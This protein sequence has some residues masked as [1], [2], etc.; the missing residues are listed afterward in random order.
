[1]Y[2]LLLDI[3]SEPGEDID[4]HQKLLKETFEFEETNHS[5]PPSPDGAHQKATG[6][7]IITAGLFIVGEI[8][9]AGT[10]ALPAAMSKASYAGFIIM[11]LVVGMSLYCG[12][13]LGWSWQVVKEQRKTTE[14]IKDPFPAIGEAA[15]GIWGRHAVSICLN[16]Q[17]FLTVVV[18]LLLSSEIISS[19]ISFHIGDLH[20]SA[21]L[22]IWLLILSLVVLPFT[23]LGTPK[24][25]WFIALA[26]A[27]TTACA[28]LLIIIKYTLIAPKDL[29]TVE[30][31]PVT[32]LSMASA[33]GTFVF[34]FTGAS[35]FPTVQSDMK[36]PDQFAKA[37]V[38]GYIATCFLYVPTAA[39]GFAVLGKDIEDSILETLSNYDKVHH[40]NRLIVSIVEILFALHFICGLVLM[41]NPFAQQ[42]EGFFN[43]PH[44]K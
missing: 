18:Y 26:A 13:L 14:P 4:G 29:S 1:M 12:L 40:L 17:I 31:A 44:S 8:A 21:N 19:F 9:G 32:F 16:V 23:W 34:A 27:A 39:G 25:F 3:A 38:V 33:F 22:R 37:I 43:V 42:M 36:K 28:V 41:I 10:V 2:L 15:T 7:T 6:L 20:S 35:L 5:G 11:I 30:K 24:D